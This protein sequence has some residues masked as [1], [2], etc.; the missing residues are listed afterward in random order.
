MVGGDDAYQAEVDEEFKS[1]LK[2][3]LETGDLRGTAA[4]GITKFVIENGQAALSEKQNSYLI[5]I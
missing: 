2:Q 4:E 3:V 1:F 5:V